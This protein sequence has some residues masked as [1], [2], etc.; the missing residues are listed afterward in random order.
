MF[1]KNTKN[2]LLNQYDLIN[3]ILYNSILTQIQL[4]LLIKK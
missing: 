2:Y 3:I 1:N 4:L